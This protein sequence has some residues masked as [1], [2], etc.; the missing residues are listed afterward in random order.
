MVVMKEQTI[1]RIS[2]CGQLAFMATTTIVLLASTFDQ[3]SRGL[4]ALP[5]AAVY[6]L[7]GGFGLEF[8]RSVWTGDAQKRTGRREAQR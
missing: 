4:E 3:A 1:K 7:A 8:I 6:A 2:W 5:G